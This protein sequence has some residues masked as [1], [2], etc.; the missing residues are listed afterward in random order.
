MGKKPIKTIFQFESID[1]DLVI[2]L[3]NAFYSILET[4]EFS[5]IGNCSRKFFY[6]V[7]WKDFFNLPLDEIP[8]SR[9]GIDDY[10]SKKF[11]KNWFDSAQWYEVYDFI[12][13]LIQTKETKFGDSFIKKINDALRTEVSAYRIVDENIIQINLEEEVQEINQAIEVT[14]VI[15]SVNTH[16]KTALNMLSDRASPDYR[17]SIKESISAVEA[18]CRILIGEEKATLGKALAIVEKKY[19]LHGSLKT[20][21]TALYGYTSDT[22]GI[23][24][25]ILED[26]VEIKFEDAKFMMV[27]CSSFINYLS[28][29]LAI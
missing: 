3:W 9:Y 28:S 1:D 17:N 2:R 19:G 7:L 22:G 20:A 15:N 12:E 21:F 6:N 18:Y 23:R 13:Y 5:R 11:I 24:H 29:K 14:D 4:L 27:S 26:D 25:A 10:L 16:L 8:Q